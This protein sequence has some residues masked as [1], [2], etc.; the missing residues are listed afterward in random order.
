MN[1]ASSNNASSS[2]VYSHGLSPDDLC[3]LLGC[4][5]VRPEIPVE[6]VSTADLDPAT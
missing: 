6:I 3:P 5:L 1:N 4:D 2:D